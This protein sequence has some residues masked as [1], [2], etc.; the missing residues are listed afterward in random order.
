MR[1]RFEIM[2]DILDETH[3]YPDGL[4]KIRL[5]YRCNL[6]F[7]QLKIYIK[8]LTDRGFLSREK[9]GTTEIYQVT[10]DGLTLL[11]SYN[12]FRNICMRNSLIE[13]KD[14]EEGI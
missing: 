4:R 11:R 7:R 1:E 9:K 8:L 13:L 3:L 12:S 5:M 6:S 2:A 14:M 10:E